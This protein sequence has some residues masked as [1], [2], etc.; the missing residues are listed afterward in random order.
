MNGCFVGAAKY[1]HV[2]EE[3]VVHHLDLLAHVLEEATDFGRK[4]DLRA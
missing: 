2:D 1:V 4:V 3:V